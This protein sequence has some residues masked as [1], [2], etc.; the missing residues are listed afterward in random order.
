MIIAFLIVFVFYSFLLSDYNPIFDKKRFKDIILFLRENKTNKKLDSFV[1]MYNK[2]HKKIK[3]RR[4]ECEI[5]PYYIEHERIQ[6][7]QIKNKLY[8]LKI[9]R[10]FSNDDCLKFNLLNAD[11]LYNN[12]GVENASKYYFKKNVEQLNDDEVIT[13][14][15]MLDNPSLYNPTRNIDGIKKKVKDYKQILNEYKPNT[16]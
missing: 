7:F 15:I 1:I 12:I 9:K 10:D 13:L 3:L 6:R 5:I 8:F 11:F 2:I 4:C 16:H 14:L